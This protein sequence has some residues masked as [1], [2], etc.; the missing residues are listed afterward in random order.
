MPIRRRDSNSLTGLAV[1]P[2]PHPHFAP[3]TITFGRRID[4][5]RWLRSSRLIRDY[6][7]PGFIDLQ[8]NGAYG[9]D[10]MTATA[11]DLLE[12]A[13][14]LAH[15]GTTSWLPTVITAPLDDF[16]RAD[17]VLAEAMAAQ[18][19]SS[20]TSGTPGAAILGMHL[21]GPFI[22][23]YRLGAHP[24]LNLLPTDEA[25]DRVL[26]LRS[27][28]MI[29]IA[30]ELDGALDAIP[31][32]VA[33]GVIVALGHSD[34][35]YAQTLAAVAAGA[36]TITHTFNAMGPLHHREPGL[37]GAALTRLQLY[38]AVIA[39]GVHVHPAALSLVC[40]S[41]N[42]YLVSDRVSPAGVASTSAMTLF[43]GLIANAT[44][45]RDAVR[46]ANG[47]LAGATASI[48]DGLRLLTQDAL[49][50]RA[51]FPR[52]SSGAAAELLGLS[53]RAR[54]Q[55]RARADLLLLDRD[56]RLKAV[57]LSGRDLN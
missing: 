50:D 18:S 47:T 2:L 20:R 10:A 51:T 22:S 11:T 3:C 25:L 15:D 9:I 19:G 13:H 56:F 14:C 40:R 33:R 8:I 37:V 38:P 49:I 23:P 44:V 24:P 7:L 48:L 6:L 55:P 46:L 53:D 36:T 29:T 54:L 32:F 45:V 30:P 17:A 21:E 26:R 42:A 1:N 41:P 28:R 16:E 31:R 12:L 39:D 5:V 34:A 4:S 52:L 43:G 27:L 35:T 57:F